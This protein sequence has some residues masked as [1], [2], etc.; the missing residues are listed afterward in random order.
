MSF[1][2]CP[3]QVVQ[4][5]FRGCSS[6]TRSI[7]PL[8]TLSDEESLE[9]GSAESTHSSLPFGKLGSAGVGSEGRAPRRVP[10]FFSMRSCELT[11]TCSTTCTH[12]AAFH[13]RCVARVSSVLDARGQEECLH[14][15]R[16]DPQRSSR[17]CSDECPAPK[18]SRHR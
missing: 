1:G 14:T 18:W 12:V 9:P 3:H 4:V 16:S 2:G 11:R 17:S 6:V 15:A 13:R 8:T 5:S 7:M 10:G